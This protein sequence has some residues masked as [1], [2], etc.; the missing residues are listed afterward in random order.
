MENWQESLIT[1]LQLNGKAERTQANYIRQI[2]IL[3]EHFH[4]T[5]DLIT[6]EE[7][8][9]Y[10]LHRRNVSKW[11]PS[12]MK[13]CY[14]GIRFFFEN[15]LKRDW[16]IFKI[17]RAKTEYRMP[18]VL[19]IE[20]VRTILAHVTSSRNHAFLTTVYSCGLR[21]TEALQL[22]VSDIDSSRM[23]IHVHQ[24]KGSKDRYVPLPQATL[25]ILRKH[26]A[27]HKNP[28]LIFPSRGIYDKGWTSD[29]PISVSTV[30]AALRQAVRAA[31]IQKRRISVHTLRHSY[32]THLLE[33][34]VN[35][36]VIQRYLGHSQL[37]TTMMYLHLTNKGQEDA[38]K[39][40]NQIMV[41]F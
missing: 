24:G 29:N 25:E 38:L 1:T 2:R 6:E 33:S 19:T 15:V 35:L 14:A 16:H 5:P 17:V 30:Q 31:G 18:T 41:R 3:T 22:Q 32:A 36:R 7:L 10:F 37:D 11:A 21:L 20:E 39:L 12:T 13:S 27:T 23:M 26:W 9:E 40:I 34:G 8:Q 28:R 4:K